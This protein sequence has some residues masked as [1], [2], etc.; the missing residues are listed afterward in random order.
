MAVGIT[1]IQAVDHLIGFVNVTCNCSVG[2][3]LYCKI[4]ISTLLSPK[5]GG[6]CHDSKKEVIGAKS[7]SKCVCPYGKSKLKSPIYTSMSSPRPR[8]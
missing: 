6:N 8:P 2:I 5:T 4:L 1:K 3:V 7:F